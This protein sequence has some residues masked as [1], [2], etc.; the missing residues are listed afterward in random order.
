MIPI[1]DLDDIDITHHHHERAR[2]DGDG[3][4]LYDASDHGVRYRSSTCDT[5][6]DSS[7]AAATVDDDDG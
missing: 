6:I 4:M 2:D 1:T 7:R 5:P 3:V